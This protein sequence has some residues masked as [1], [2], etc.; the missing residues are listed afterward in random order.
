MVK[1]NFFELFFRAR[2]TYLV[3]G[4][5]C[6]I[7]GYSQDGF[8]FSNSFFGAGV[9]IFLVGLLLVILNRVL[10]KKW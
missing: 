6:V 1:R 5:G 8:D 2:W 9:V 4:I 3:I 10:K 7:I